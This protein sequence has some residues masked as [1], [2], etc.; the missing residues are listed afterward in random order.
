MSFNVFAVIV[1]LVIFI[2][3]SKSK[4]DA[5]ADH[6]ISKDGAMHKPGLNLPYQNS[7]TSCHGED[8]RGGTDAAVSCFECH[9]QLWRVNKND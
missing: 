8:L 9:G 6:T 2:G 4:Y 5:P 3:C 7:C 1:Y